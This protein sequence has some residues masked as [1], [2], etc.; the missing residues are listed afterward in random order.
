MTHVLDDTSAD[1]PAM[2]TEL[3]DITNVDVC[4]TSGRERPL[5]DSGRDRIVRGSG[6]HV[7]VVLRHNRL[8]T[9]GPEVAKV[10]SAARWRS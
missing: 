10:C 8:G 3:D 9:D 6:D 1:F 7:F 2:A 5:V 4:G